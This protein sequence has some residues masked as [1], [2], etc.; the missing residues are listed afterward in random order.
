MDFRA[1]IAKQEAQRD[2]ELLM[3]MRSRNEAV[4]KEVSRVVK[5]AVKPYK[6][7]ESDQRLRNISTQNKRKRQHR[8]LSNTFKYE[9]E[10]SPIKT[11]FVKDLLLRPDL[12]EKLLLKG[13]QMKEVVETVDNIDE[14]RISPK[15]GPAHDVTLRKVEK[16]NP[17]E[18]TEDNQGNLLQNI[19]YSRLHG[20]EHVINNAQQALF[21]VKQSFIKP[22]D[23]LRQQ[24]V[25][26]E[27]VFEEVIDSLNQNHS[28][29]TSEQTVRDESCNNCFVHNFRYIINNGNICKTASPIYSAYLFIMIFTANENFKQRAAIRNTWLTYSKQNTGLIRYAFLLGKPK[30]ESLHSMVL[31]ENSVH[32]DILEEDFVDSYMNL[33]Y[34][35]IMGFKWAVTYC[36]NVQ[37]VLKTD[38]DMYVNIPN[39]IKLLQQSDGELDNVIVGNCFSDANPNRDNS[40]KWYVSKDVY[41]EERYPDFCTGTGYLTSLKI[42]EKI[43]K[44]SPN[45]PFFHLEDVYVGLCLRRIGGTVRRVKGFHNNQPELDA[46]TYKGDNLYTSHWISPETMESIWRSKCFYFT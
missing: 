1:E 37:Y 30:N 12:L 28:V 2:V 8:G 4:K 18:E 23:E 41:K 17:K 42:V 10:N 20:P 26:L 34:K 13:A 22:S 27:K 38:D 9:S 15:Q 21:F 11:L 33:T 19:S 36:P 39:M 25:V 24:H 14:Q 45:V 43:Y 5:M 44:I 46:C 6:S 7:D 40:S 16:V 29:K 31:W 3:T 32:H 35:T